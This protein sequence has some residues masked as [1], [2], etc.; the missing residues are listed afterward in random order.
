MIGILTTNSLHRVVELIQILTSDYLIRTKGQIV[1]TFLNSNKIIKMLAQALQ[2][3]L[4]EYLGQLPQVLATLDSL[5]QKLTQNCTDQE[6]FLIVLTTQLTRKSSVRKINKTPVTL[7]PH[8]LK[9][10][11]L[12]RS[13][14]LVKLNLDRI[15]K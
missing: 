11:S 14:S 6:I 15:Q 2:T 3:S 5:N 1:K 10:K 9:T 13:Y 8:H 4:K 12:T 7:R